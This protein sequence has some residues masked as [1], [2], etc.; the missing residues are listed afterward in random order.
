MNTMTAHKLEIVSL[1]DH[2][3]AICACGK[4]ACAFTRNDGEDD[5]RVVEMLQDAFAEHRHEAVH[6]QFNAHIAHCTTCRE[7]PL[8][9]CKAGQQL[10]LQAVTMEANA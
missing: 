9:L 5:A 2:P 8:C 3:A 4:W 7:D 10:L 1:G 6:A